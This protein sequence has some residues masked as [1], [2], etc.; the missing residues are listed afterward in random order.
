M[1]K[2]KI[3]PLVSSRVCLR[4]LEEVDL[5]MTLA[6]RNQD[7]IR[8]WFVHSAILTWEQHHNWCQRYFQR[9]NDFIF[10]IE[11]RQERS[12]PVGQISL[13]NIEWE[14][15]RAEYG[16]LMIGETLGAGKG[17]AK[18]ATQLLLNYAF[19]LLGLTE[20]YLEVFSHNLPAI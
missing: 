6:W 20:V 1:A 10:I 18:E 15:Q 16:R 12:L 7:H 9:D 11:D 3:S 17:F 14:R 13:Y 4:L 2:R 5:P 8:Q 19:G